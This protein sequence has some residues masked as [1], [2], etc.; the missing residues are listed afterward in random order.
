MAV[1]AGAL[2][3]VGPGVP[4]P[5]ALLTAVGF[6]TSPMGRC[7]RGRTGVA[8]TEALSPAGASA[9]VDGSVG[10]RRRLY[11]SH[12]IWTGRNQVHL[13]VS[14]GSRLAG[15]RAGSDRRHREQQSMAGRGGQEADTERTVFR[16]GPF[17]LTRRHR[18]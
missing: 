15:G 1:P 16:Q 6:L 4:A 14:G 18:Q 5:R 11:L 17:V 8:V 9:A 7:R 13:D 12:R 10:R 3:R 2:G